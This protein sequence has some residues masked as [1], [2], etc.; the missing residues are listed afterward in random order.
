[1]AIFTDITL[2]KLF[3]LAIVNS[4]TPTIATRAEASAGALSGYIKY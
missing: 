2:W 3:H 1:M 4:K